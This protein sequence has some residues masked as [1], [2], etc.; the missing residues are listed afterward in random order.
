M[1]EH[2]SAVTS[3]QAVSG[4]SPA[5]APNSSPSGAASVQLKSAIRGRPIDVQMS[6]LAPSAVSADAVQRSAVHGAVVEGRLGAA[7]EADGPSTAAGATSLGAG[8]DRT[9][10]A[11][12]QRSILRDRGAS[13]AAMPVQRQEGD[14]NTNAHTTETTS[15][16]TTNTSPETTNTET[17]QTEG[18]GPP[19]FD[20]PTT[21]PAFST[22]YHNHDVVG[23][24]LADLKLLRERF[25]SQGGDLRREFVRVEAD[26]P[27][28]EAK[29]NELE[30][31]QDQLDKTQKRDLEGEIASLEGRADNE[32]KTMDELLEKAKWLADQLQKGGAEKEAAIEGLEGVMNAAMALAAQI[33]PEGTQKGR[34]LYKEIDEKH[35]PALLEEAR[36][37]GMPMADVAALAVTYREFT[38]VFIRDEVMNDEANAEIYYLRDLG[39]YDRREGPTPGDIRDKIVAR[40]KKTSPKLFPADFDLQTATPEQLDAIY[41]GMIGSAKTTNPAAN[42]G[43][44]SGNQNNNS[45]GGGQ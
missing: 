45:G 14:P 10:G 36:A 38:R 37:S 23:P 40:L 42:A 41:Q 32:G 20:G 7:A 44:A 35:N 13:A 17:P 2:H 22:Y 1:S 34:D 26:L 15:P 9:P 4:P 3:G 33:D 43:A 29:K 5:S 39:A 24:M 8:A 12:V 30:A 25:I 16:E 28:L 19:P 27:L 31:K 6:M 11:R 21:Y 18:E